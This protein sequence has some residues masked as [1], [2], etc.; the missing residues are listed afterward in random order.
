MTIETVKIPAVLSPFADALIA[1]QKPFV[2]IAATPID[3]EP[4]RDPLDLRQSKF[5]GNPFV[6]ED[7]EYPQDKHGKPLVLIAQINFSE[8]PPLD[9]FPSAGMFQLF[10]NPAEWSAGITG[11]DSRSESGKIVYLSPED[12]EKAPRTTF[13]IVETEAYES[14]PIG[15]I[16]RLQ[17]ERAIDTGNCEDSQ[18]AFEFGD[19][20]YWEFE[21][22]LGDAEKQAF[23]DYFSTADGHKLGGYAY[24]TQ[25]DIRGYE[26]GLEDDI[27]I[28][29]IDSDDEIMF[30][31][32][33]IG[34]VFISPED[35]ANLNFENAYFYWDCC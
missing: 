8:V 26:E 18:L 31:D 27:Q 32:S 2:R 23:R 13:P 35:L 34:H 4:D 33:G 11:W 16:H 3:G 14:L 19:L 30:G 1:K 15:K 22:S 12:L 24:F 6:P 17:F 10:F 20:D 29:Q 5:L 9:G 21:E 7:A 25:D 28:L